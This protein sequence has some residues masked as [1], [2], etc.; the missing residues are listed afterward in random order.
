MFYLLILATVAATSLLSGILG[1]AGGMV[2]MAVLITT[3]GVASAMLLH[4]AVQATANGSRA[5]FL[6]RYVHWP[7]L[8]MY[9]AG[10][11]TAT[12]AFT[13]IALV[14]HPGVVLILVGAFPWLA[15]FSKRLSGL[16]VTKPLT[17]FVCGVVVTAAQLLAGASG[18]LLDVFYLRS[19]LNRQQIVASKAITQALGHLLKI[20]YYGLIIS[21][22]AELP[23]WFVMAALLMAIGGTRAGTWILAK[24]NDTDFQKVSQVIILTIATACLVHGILLLWPSLTA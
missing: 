21:L 24:W 6:R 5:W 1:M 23:W 7:I 12:A 8:P 3:M 16:D 2:L 19:P 18:P 13:L 17:T 20:Y 14:P 11:A 9:I 4:G 15:R 10:A 22:P